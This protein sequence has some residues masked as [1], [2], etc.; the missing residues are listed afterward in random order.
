MSVAET[1]LNWSGVLG[2]AAGL[3]TLV[4]VRAQRRKLLSESKSVDADAAAK[5]S[6]AAV[7]L[8]EPARRQV[9]DMEAQLDRATDRISRLEEALSSAHAEASTLR[10]QLADMTKD[11]RAAHDEIRRLSSND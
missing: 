1:I 6:E 2:G 9:K 8:L 10:G 11:L 3:T 7:E 4:T 5:L